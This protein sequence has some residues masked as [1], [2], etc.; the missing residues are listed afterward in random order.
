MITRMPTTKPFS[1]VL[2]LSLLPAFFLPLH[3]Q[4]WF[5]DSTFGTQGAL[6]VGSGNPGD[7]L[8]G[9]LELPDGKLL[10]GYQSDSP[11][12]C[13]LLQFLPNGQPDPNFDPAGQSALPETYWTALTRQ[14]DGK[15]LAGGHFQF[16]SDPRSGLWRFLPDGTP[17]SSFGLF[18]F[19]EKPLGD[20]LFQQIE[21]IQPL[22]DGQI[23]VLG[24][25]QDN[26]N[27]QNTRLTRWNA[28]GTRDWSFG[29][30]GYAGFKFPFDQ[31]RFNVHL[32]Q[33]DGKI[34]VGGD[35]QATG[36]RNAL[37]LRYLPDG[38]P[39]NNF[40]TNGKLTIDFNFT[41]DYLQELLLYPDGRLLAVCNATNTS[42]QQSLPALAR[43]TSGGKLDPAFGQAGKVTFPPGSP[44]SNMVAVRIIPDEYLLGVLTTLG[45]VSNTLSFEVKR[46]LPNGI[47]DSTA[48]AETFGSDDWNAPRF[49]SAAF[50]W[51]AAGQLLYSESGLYADPGNP[52]LLLARYRFDGSL[53]GAPA[54]PLRP[55]LS[56][57]I[58]PNPGAGAAGLWG[59]ASQAVR[60]VFRLVSPLGVEV[61]QQVLTLDPTED[62]VADLGASA[63]WAPGVYGWTFKTEGGQA[64]SGLWVHLE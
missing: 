42:T 46:F 61:L 34:L 52:G 16:F 23:L 54:S 21:G 31:Y 14:N 43:Y 30:S 8:N 60:G 20:F 6:W 63:Y 45:P 15:I 27:E 44:F 10:L 18:G 24:I 22:P 7:H 59:F 53:L 47:P 28:D 4:T 36:H 5:R 40:G 51:T 49:P 25:G 38:A 41:D 39:D 50:G 19:A 56:L 13:R 32:V 17:D 1:A 33:A 11:R 64:L 37:L 3:A 55:A 12:Q 2:A 26:G 29:T 62:K 48:L 9:R 58:S 35:T 57:R